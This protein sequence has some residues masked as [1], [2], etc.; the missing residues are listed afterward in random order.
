MGVNRRGMELIALFKRFLLWDNFPLAIAIILLFTTK[1][2]I[3]MTYH[4]FI[5]YPDLFYEFELNPLAK[6]FF[7]TSNWWIPSMIYALGDAF[8]VLIA[9]LFEPRKY[10]IFS[11]YSCLTIRVLCLFD[12]V[13]PLLLGVYGWWLRL[14]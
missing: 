8:V 13:S 4:V 6:Q 2:D 12:S 14:V 9:Y 11:D 10:R 1:M 7:G 3:G 5:N